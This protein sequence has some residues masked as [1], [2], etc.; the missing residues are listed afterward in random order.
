MSGVPKQDRFNRMERK[1]ERAWTMLLGAELDADSYGFWGVVEDLGQIRVELER[2]QRDL[3][4]G[5]TRHS[6]V[7]RKEAGHKHVSE[8]GY[9]RDGS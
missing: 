6:A 8:S 2:V 5:R 4:S 3:L 9:L 7:R 1:L